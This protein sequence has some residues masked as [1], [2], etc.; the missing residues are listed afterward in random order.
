MINRDPSFWDSIANHPQ[1][2]PF[3]FMGKEAGSLE[4]L[5]T[6]PDALPMASENGGLIFVK[7]DLVGL[8]RELHTM[9]RP[10]GWGRE[11]ARHAPLFMDEAFNHCSLITTHEQ[12]G[13]WRTRPP[14]SHGWTVS[15]E[16]MDCGLN[17]KLRLWL[18][19]REAWIG[20]PVGR[21]LQCP[22]SPSS[23]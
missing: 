13:E 23:H 10:E 2:S 8:V 19:T 4:G 12:E 5:V 1:V 14:R 3:V 17:K 22:S 20:S 15:G 11:V 21:K 9:Y 18:L 16:F 6:H 7:M